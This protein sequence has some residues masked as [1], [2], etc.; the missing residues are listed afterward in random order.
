MKDATAK[1]YK[2]GNN[3]TVLVRKF[4]QIFDILILH[5][6]I[7]LEKQEQ[8]FY[9]CSANLPGFFTLLPIRTNFLIYSMSEFEIG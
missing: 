7:F 1:L 5:I 3:F 2:I 4:V 8:Y 6:S 9:F